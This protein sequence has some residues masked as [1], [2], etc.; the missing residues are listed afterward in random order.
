V[1]DRSSH[2]LQKSPPPGASTRKA[3][4]EDISGPND[5]VE[6]PGEIAPEEEEEEGADKGVRRRRRDT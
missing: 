3:K 4:K 2:V 1:N 5:V 6:K